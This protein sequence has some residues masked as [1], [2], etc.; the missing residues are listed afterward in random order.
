M[1]YLVLLNILLVA[2]AFGVRYG[3]SAGP[4]CSQNNKSEVTCHFS[5][6]GM[7]HRNLDWMGSFCDGTLIIDGST[8][9]HGKREAIVNYEYTGAR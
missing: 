8:W 3:S 5:S 2:T 6:G 4:K 7:Q 9:Q 1:G